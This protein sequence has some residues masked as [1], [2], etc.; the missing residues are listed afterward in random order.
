[1]KTFRS[2]VLTFLKK[3]KKMENKRINDKKILPMYR[4]AF[5][6]VPP[7]LKP[8]S[9][10]MWIKP[11]SIIFSVKAERHVIIQTL[12]LITIRHRDQ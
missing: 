8:M 5:I 6:E 7:F 4:C 3:K 11:L 10:I 1:M 12:N 9:L 2:V